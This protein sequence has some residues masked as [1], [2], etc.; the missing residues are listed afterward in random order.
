MRKLH[1][2]FLMPFLLLLLTTGYGLLTADAAVPHLINYQGRL[3]D[4][5]GN[6]LNGSYNLTF[7]IYDAETAGNLLW[8]EIQNGVVIQ[9][10]IFS[11]LLGSVTN[12][13]LAFDIPYF[14]EIKVGS[15]VMSPRQRI[16][17]AGYAMRAEKAEDANTIANVGVSA[18]PAPNKIL[19]LDNNAKIAQSVIALKVYD[20]GWFAASAATAYTKTHNLGTTK[21]ILNLYCAD[22]SS[23][24]NMFNM[25]LNNGNEGNG[26]IVTA[27]IQNVTPTTLTVQTGWG[28]SPSTIACKLDAAGY[29]ILVGAGKYFRVVAIALE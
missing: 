6:P 14:L 7:R 3:T 26:S 23:G 18:T 25:S 22:D 27:V 13:N 16:T 24:T 8:E 1:K 15:E 12:L 19:P 2:V 11:V 20:S 4:S 5:G 10:G 28:G 21:L 29:K 9:K 17:S